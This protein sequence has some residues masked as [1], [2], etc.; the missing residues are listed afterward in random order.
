MFISLEL[1]SQ[2]INDLKEDLMRDAVRS[3]RQKKAE[4]GLASV[5]QI[6]GAD[7]VKGA[8]ADAAL[9]TFYRQKGWVISG[10]AAPAAAPVRKKPGAKVARIPSPVPAVR[11]RAKIQVIKQ[12]VGE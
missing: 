1:V 5:A 7:L 4:D 6:D 11:K 10:D 2:I 9:S 8:L 12:A 3:I